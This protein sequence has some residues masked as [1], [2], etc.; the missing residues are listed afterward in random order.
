MLTDSD[1]T[2]L[3][4]LFE[5][6]FVTNT[7]RYFHIDDNDNKC[8]YKINGYNDYKN[9]LVRSFPIGTI[10][11]IARIVTTDYNEYAY[12][13]NSE[14]KSKI[15][16]CDLNASE[17]ILFQENILRTQHELKCIEI[18]KLIYSLRN[19]YFKYE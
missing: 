5:L 11:V 7:T 9:F 16:I 17:E 2:I 19:E 8:R 14:F 6:N 1:K 15:I 4:A 10:G 13:E 12:Y 18:I 3:R